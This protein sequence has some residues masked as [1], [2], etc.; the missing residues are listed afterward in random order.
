MLTVTNVEVLPI[1]LLPMANWTLATLM[2][3]LILRTQVAPNAHFWYNSRYSPKCFKI[4]GEN[5]HAQQNFLAE[6]DSAHLLE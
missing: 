4:E 2:F 3:H 5:E 1:P 6:P